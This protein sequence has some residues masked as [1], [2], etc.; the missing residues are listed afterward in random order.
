[1]SSRRSSRSRSPVMSR[2]VSSYRSPSP[3]KKHTDESSPSSASSSPTNA[4]SGMSSI[5]AIAMGY[6]IG[7]STN[8][9]EHTT[10]RDDNPPP[11]SDMKILLDAKCGD[12]LF[13]ENSVDDVECAKLLEQFKKNCKDST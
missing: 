5:Q 8:K 9:P 7:H 12:G 11:C 2:R 4:S 6:V 13:V 3:L 10:T 1:M